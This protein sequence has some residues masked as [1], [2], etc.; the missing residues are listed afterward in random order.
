LVMNFGCKKATQ[1]VQFDVKAGRVRTVEES[2]TLTGKVHG[3]VG[4]GPINAQ[5]ARAETTKI[6]VTDEKPKAKK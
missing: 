2:R 3:M 5:I 6:T 4:P 1:T